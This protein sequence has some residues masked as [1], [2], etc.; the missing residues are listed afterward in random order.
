LAISILKF[1]LKKFW[2]LICVLKKQ[3]P[4]PVMGFSGVFVHYSDKISNRQFIIDFAKVV[5]FINEQK[6]E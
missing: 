5:D 3:K 2:V 1:A 6:Q 4:T